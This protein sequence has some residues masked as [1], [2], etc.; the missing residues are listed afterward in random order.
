MTDSISY[1]QFRKDPRASWTIRLSRNLQYQ[2]FK[3]GLWLGDRLTL[4]QLQK[5]GRGIGKLAYWLLSKERGIARAQLERVFPEVSEST[6]SQWVH[7]CFKHFGMLLMEFFALNHLMKHHQEHVN[8]EGY[9]IV[10]QALAKG[11]GVIFVGLHMGNWEMLLPFA[12][13]KGHYAAL[14][15]T[16]V[17]DERLNELIRQ[18]RQRG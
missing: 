3:F 1:S 9:P 10:E 6:R 4:S 11:K 2:L 14:V 8:V 5:I 12:A 7:E 17:P 18:H 16:N 13:E 15:T